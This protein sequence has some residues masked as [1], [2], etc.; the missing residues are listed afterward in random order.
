ML[1]L[2]WINRGI[3]GCFGGGALFCLVC[4]TDIV[5]LKGLGFSRGDVRPWI[6][7]LG[8]L[9]T[10]P[11]ALMVVFM[12]KREAAHFMGSR[13]GDWGPP[14]TPCF[15]TLA[16][17]WVM[18]ALGL[19]FHH[20]PPGVLYAEQISK[21]FGF[22]WGVLVVC[23]IVIGFGSILMHYL[24][25]RIIRLAKRLAKSFPVQTV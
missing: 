20:A 2:I 15:R 3:I 9:L 17:S 6:E 24:R 16:A 12:S 23:G 10:V 18:L 22:A 11:F 5:L 4:L 13:P 7:G 19:A 1:R 21:A 25:P 8:M 14:F